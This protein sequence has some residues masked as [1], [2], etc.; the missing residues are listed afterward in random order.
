MLES[1]GDLLFTFLPLLLFYFLQCCL[2]TICVLANVPAPTS[3]TLHI[4]LIFH[5]SEIKHNTIRQ[6]KIAINVQCCCHRN[7]GVGI[8]HLALV[9]FVGGAIMMCHSPHCLQ[10]SPGYTEFHNE[11]KSITERIN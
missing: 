11:Y 1:S 10:R 9:R 8:Y 3:P 4:T 7:R 2:R 5:F 6:L